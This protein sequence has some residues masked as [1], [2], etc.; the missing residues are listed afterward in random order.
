MAESWTKTMNNGV[1]MRMLIE[2]PS[3]KPLENQVMLR[4]C[5]DSHLQIVYR[6]LGVI[7]ALHCEWAS[8]LSNR[9]LLLTF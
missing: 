2:R 8:P 1:G 9:L 5:E 3:W 6:T 4:I 7:L